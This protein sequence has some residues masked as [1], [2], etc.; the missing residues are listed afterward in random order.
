MTVRDLNAEADK[1]PVSLRTVASGLREPRPL[2]LWLKLG[3]S[4]DVAVQVLWASLLKRQG[5]PA[6]E[7]T[8]SCCHSG[9]GLWRE[10]RSR[11]GGFQLAA[12]VCFENT[13]V[14]RACNRLK[15]PLPSQ[16]EALLI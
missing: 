1:P 8:A 6:D 9:P 13:T 14:L 4:D 7:I 16:G 10:A 12:E 2:V 3:A 15:G 11:E 5:S